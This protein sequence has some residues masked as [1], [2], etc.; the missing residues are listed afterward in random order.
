ML[1]RLRST[2]AK[3]VIIQFSNAAGNR[4]LSIAMARST[5]LVGESTTVKCQAP[6]NANATPAQANPVGDAIAGC[7]DAWRS[8]VSAVVSRHVEMPVFAKVTKWFQSETPGLASASPR[9]NSLT[10]M[11]SRRNVRIRSV[12]TTATNTME[13]PTSPNTSCGQPFGI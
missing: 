13:K 2:V 7:A 11:G 6:S 8:N 4:S 12:L 5:V 10:S 9:Q 3:S 1:P